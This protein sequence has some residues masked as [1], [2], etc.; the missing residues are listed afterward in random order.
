MARSVQ[1]DSEDYVRCMTELNARFSL[2]NWSIKD[3]VDNDLV[4]L[5]PAESAFLQLRKSYELVVFASMAWN[6]PQMEE[7]W[8]RFEKDWN[9]SDIV[10]RIQKQNPNFLPHTNAVHE[11]STFEGLELKLIS[12][13]PPYRIDGEKLKAQHGKLGK[14]LHARNPFAEKIDYRAELIEAIAAKS[15]LQTAMSQHVTFIGDDGDILVTKMD[16]G[17]GKAEST[18]LRRVK[19]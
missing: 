8:K 7:S 4:L 18:A 5:G 2:F 14:L 9:L 10:K 17:D 16:R 15:E 13:T 3:F 11:G 6:L 19:E 12:D 1:K